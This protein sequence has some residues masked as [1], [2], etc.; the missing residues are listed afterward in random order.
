[1]SEV[2][3][4]RDCVE[5]MEE[6]EES[7][8]ANA[9]NEVVAS[10]TASRLFELCLFGDRIPLG[11]PGS[12]RVLRLVSYGV[13]M[14]CAPGRS[15]RYLQA[16]PP[17]PSYESSSFSPAS[18]ILLEEGAEVFFQSRGCEEEEDRGQILVRTHS[19]ENK[20]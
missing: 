10:A 16:T 1:M 2:V 9:V 18:P 20:F 5:E 12:T 11:S 17:P 14:L 6:E 4:E 15:H 19:S 8:K 7:F 3:A 13:C